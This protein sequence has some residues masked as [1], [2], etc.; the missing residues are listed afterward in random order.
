MVRERGEIHFREQ[1]QDG[2]SHGTRGME[3]S[4][5]GPFV[6]TIS[7]LDNFAPIIN[8]DADFLKVNYF[9]QAE[10]LD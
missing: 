4:V 1:S 10:C 5:E 9:A 6:P 3:T 7:V 2:C 8:V